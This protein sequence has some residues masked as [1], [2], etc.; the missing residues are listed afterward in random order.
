MCI[1]DIQRVIGFGCNVFTLMVNTS[2]NVLDATEDFVSMNHKNIK[3]AN[4]IGLQ[5]ILH[6]KR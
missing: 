1:F 6:L 4:F 5:G 3:G 2:T